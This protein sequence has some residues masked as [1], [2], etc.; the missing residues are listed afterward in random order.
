MNT[1]ESNNYKE[2][3]TN[4]KPKSLIKLTREVEDVKPQAQDH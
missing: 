1:R 3:D 4:V 2:V